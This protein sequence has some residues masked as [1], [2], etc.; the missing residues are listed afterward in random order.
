MNIYNQNS[1]S[2]P[3]VLYSWAREVF[4]LPPFCYYR[5]RGRHP[6]AAM[7]LRSVL[8][9]LLLFAFQTATA[10]PSNSMYT[11]R[12]SRDQISSNGVDAESSL[13]ATRSREANHNPGA[14]ARSPTYDQYPGM[15]LH[16]KDDWEKEISLCEAG[17]VSACRLSIQA[18]QSDPDP[19]VTE[20]MHEETSTLPLA[21]KMPITGGLEEDE[22]S[23]VR[24]L[25][26][27]GFLVVCCAVVCVFTVARRF[28]SNIPLAQSKEKAQHA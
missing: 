8:S 18:A 10:A 2:F 22:I 11:Q 7:S 27:T 3:Q 13:L 28:M 14:N 21:L 12:N 15:T 23:N 5:P 25:P 20:E 24:L 19:R 9:L 17:V 6:A 16:G 26:S 4:G 1:S